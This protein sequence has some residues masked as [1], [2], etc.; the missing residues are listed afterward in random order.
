M[1]RRLVEQQHVWIATTAS[2]HK[3]NTPLLATRQVLDRGVLWW[4]PERIHG[5]LDRPLEVPRTSGLDLVFELGLA[6]PELLEV[7][8]RVG[9]TG[10]HGIVI[11]EELDGVAGP[12]HDVRLHVLRR[13]ELRFLLEVADGETRRQPGVTGVAVVEAAHDLEQRRLA[14]TVG[15]QHADLRPRVERQGDVL[16]HL[17]VGWVEPTDLVHR[18]DELSRHGAERTGTEASG[19]SNR[20]RA[21]ARR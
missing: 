9:P 10:E 5:D 8:V 19:C 18:V 17:T 3:C 4:Q 15:A 21:L 13:V 6:G 1:V 16:E 14:G 2:W 11:G 20:F 12:V 7:G